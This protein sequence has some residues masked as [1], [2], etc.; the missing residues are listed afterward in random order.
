MKKKLS[1]IE[2]LAAHINNPETR[3]KPIPEWIREAGRAAAERDERKR[4]ERLQAGGYEPPWTWE[5]Y[6][7]RESMRWRMGGGED[8]ISEFCEFLRRMSEQEYQDYL[9]KYPEHPEWDGFYDM[10]R[11]W[12]QGG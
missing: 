1:P 9:A 5:P 3:E 12:K 6:Y 4:E 2:A 10:A 11:P 8:E 7:P